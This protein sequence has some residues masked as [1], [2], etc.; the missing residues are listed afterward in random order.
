MLCDKGVEGK[1]ENFALSKQVIN[2]FKLCS[3]LLRRKSV[4]ILFGEFPVLLDGLHLLVMFETLT[5]REEVMGTEPERCFHCSSDGKT[6][7]HTSYWHRYTG[8]LLLLLAVVAE[9][10]MVCFR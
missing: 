9:L 3:S 7:E 1:G 2:R 4:N 10:G 6:S 8:S 5:S